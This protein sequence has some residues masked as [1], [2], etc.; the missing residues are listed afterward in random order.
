MIDTA[1]RLVAAHLVNQETAETLD[2]LGATIQLLTRPEGDDLSPCV[3]RGMIPPAGVVPL[4]SHADPETFIAISG[5]VSG[6]VDERAGGAWARIEPGTVFH[7]PG[8]ARHA[9]RNQ[10]M[11]PAVMFVVS[12]SRIGRFFQ[13]IGVQVS[14]HAQ[15][16]GP[17]SRKRIQHFLETAQRYE[18]WNATPEENARIG[19]TLAF[20]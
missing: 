12:T 10:A 9:F 2:V 16:S 13:E 17:P 18:Y 5:E 1:T 20:A 11:E 4:H 7:V 15:P 6:L 19:I 3:M 14:P 8:G